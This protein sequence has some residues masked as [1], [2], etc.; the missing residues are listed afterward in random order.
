MRID[1]FAAENAVQLNN[2]NVKAEDI[3]YVIKLSDVVNRKTNQPTGK[4][5][6]FMSGLGSVVSDTISSAI[7]N[8][9]FVKTNNALYMLSEK[10][11]PFMFKTEEVSVTAAIDK[12]I[13]KVSAAFSAGGIESVAFKLTNENYEDVFVGNLRELLDDFCNEHEIEGYKLFDNFMKVRLSNHT[14]NVEKLYEF[15]PYESFA[16]LVSCD[17]KGLYLFNTKTKILFE[18]IVAYHSRGEYCQFI[19]YEGSQT[20]LCELAYKDAEFSKL[21]LNLIRDE[22]GNEVELEIPFPD[23][24]IKAE[25][26]L[27]VFGLNELKMIAADQMLYSMQGST[28]M[29]CGAFITDNQ[30][31]VKTIDG[32]TKSYPNGDKYAGVLSML[33]VNIEYIFG[34]R[35]VPQPFIYHEEIKNLTID[36]NGI[37]GGDVFYE[38]AKMENY[39][40]CTEK[41]NCKISFVYNNES[42]NLTT[43]NSLGVSVSN[44]QEKVQVKSV[45]ESYNVNQLYALYYQ[46]RTKNFMA[47]TFSEI[48]KTDKMLN[49]NIK[50][51]DVINAMRSSDSAVLRGAFQ[52]LVGKFKNVDDLQSDLIQ[53]ISLMEIQRRRIQKLGDEWVTYYPH[54]MASIQ[55][56]WLKYIFAPY[57]KEETLNTEYWKCVAQFKRILQGSNA[58]VQKSMNEIGMCTSKLSSVLPDDVK[59][60][61]ITS[62]LRI[63]SVDKSEMLKTGTN[64]MLGITTGL[65]LGNLLMRGI[66]GTSPMMISMSAKMLVDAY[67]KDVNSRKDI[68][69]YGLQTLE[70][71]QILMKG[72]RIQIL[73]IANGVGEYN[74][75]CLKR[76]TDIFK[77]L[78]DEAKA[79]VKERLTIALKDNIVG[80]IDEKYLE[81]LP[82]MNVR[83][84]NIIEDIDTSLNSRNA[85]IAEFK[86]NMFI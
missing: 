44:L 28:A 71:W 13:I 29:L 72:M 34:D 18:Q 11:S 20:I 51:Q 67:T 86:D 24:L 16:T 55:T 10:M 9:Y 21:E 32:V 19:F 17:E 84:S 58:Y 48:F 59:R 61:D 2:I 8:S 30:I 75:I 42:V 83:I 62:A 50:V 60:A 27:S 47:A 46:R 7:H 64:I 6:G 35:S 65:E 82:Q 85:I 3:H 66:Y 15:S 79:K 57:I 45:M 56:E 63:N 12:G 74:K 80:D 4:L 23:D 41:F 22:E 26:F 53:K 39:C 54:Y 76:D 37:K 40:Y 25:M 14:N 33:P 36:E 43:A 70:W 68:K 49:D 78:P 31:F 52:S 5:S 1:V 38:F 73:E 69:A 81:I 77:A